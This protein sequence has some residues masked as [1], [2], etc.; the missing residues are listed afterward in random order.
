MAALRLL[1][2]LNN[3]QGADPH[4]TWG[5]LALMRSWVAVTA[6]RLA[7]GLHRHHTQLSAGVD[8]GS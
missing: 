2:L 7:L 3:R 1:A 5:L 6:V 4:L 8:R